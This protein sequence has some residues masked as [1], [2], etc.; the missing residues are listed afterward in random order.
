MADPLV[1]SAPR[2]IEIARE[3]RKLAK[4]KLA[5]ACDGPSVLVPSKELAY[6]VPP[7]HLAE[8]VTIAASGDY[9]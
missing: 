9:S 4:A 6:D 5:E 1:N 7:L 2:V 8:S 3:R